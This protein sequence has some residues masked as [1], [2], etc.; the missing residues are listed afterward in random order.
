MIYVLSEID[1]EPKAYDEALNGDEGDQ[2]KKAM[3]EEMS[4]F[5]CKQIHG[6]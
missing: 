2:W 6:Y 5:A 4:T 3:D 1:E